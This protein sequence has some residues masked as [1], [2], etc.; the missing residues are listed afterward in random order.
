MPSSQDFDLLIVGSGP[1]GVHAAQEAVASGCKVGLLDI[2]YTD[3]RFDKLIPPKPFSEIR[4]NDPAQSVY[5]L[6]DDPEAAFRSQARAGA[7]LTPARQHMIRD[8][9]ELFPLNSRTFL[10]LQ[11]SG[12]GGLGIGWGANCFALE[13][14]EL[15]QIG[16]PAAEMKEFYATAA[17]EIGVSGPADDVLS[18]FIAN[19]DRSALQ[20][21][22]QLDSN[23]E[24]LLARYQP[25]K[26][27]FLDGG[28]YLGQSLLAMLS[29]PLEG[30]ESNAYR[31]M[32]FWGDV[33]R[34]VYRP[35]FTMEK[36]LRAP[37]FVHLGGRLA[38]R[39]EDGGDS[40]R[41]SCRNLA[42]NS[43]ESVMARKLILTAGAINSA[44]LAL[45]SLN[46]YDSRVPIL[47]NANHWIAA[48]NLRMLGKP[49][50]DARH[51]LSQLTALLKVEARE[52]GYISAQ[53]Y[54][55]RSLLLSRMLKSIPFP[56]SI[57]LLFLRLTATAFTCVNVHFPDAPSDGRWM[58][59]DRN[60]SMRV[61]CAWKEEET[62]WMNRQERRLLKHLLALRCVPLGIAKPEH[63]ASIHY[64]GTLP[65][66]EAGRPLTTDAAGRLHGFRSVF[67]AD[68]STWR[69]LPAKGLTLTLMANARRIARQAVRD[70]REEG[71]ANG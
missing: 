15:E 21:A 6:G 23:A 43:I 9:D 68:A 19:L 26:G 34:S 39:F 37:N 4:S 55:Y 35:R 1:S 66:H 45:A 49:A 60:G 24:S 7:H 20:P 18:P 44:K 71:S 40:V 42:T 46:A 54:S 10:P 63:G 3:E 2:G 65:Y 22:L 11:S 50:R 62:E 56:P 52:R 14:F 59:L 27:T 25:R 12:L 38:L 32:D 36:L 64:A 29:K 16:L 31:D 61:E 5:F 17:R 58:S 57:G 48:V 51:S 69:F 67:V 30:R 33:G 8:M 13:D 70:L 41:L 28:F 53:F 47:C